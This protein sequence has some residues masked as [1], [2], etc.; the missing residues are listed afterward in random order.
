MQR[1]VEGR[2]ARR[3]RARCPGP[4]SSGA[5]SLPNSART[6]KILSVFSRLSSTYWSSL[7]GASRSAALGVDRARATVVP[8]PSRR[9]WRRASRPSPLPSSSSVMASSRSARRFSSQRVGQLV[10]RTR[11]RACRR[12]GCRRLLHRW[13]LGWRTPR[14]SRGLSPVLPPRPGSTARLTSFARFLRQ[15]RSCR[16]K[17]HP[18]RNIGQSRSPVVRLASAERGPRHETACRDDPSSTSVR[19]C[20]LQSRAVHTPVH[21]ITRAETP[22]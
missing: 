18:R 20:G 8:T 19:D 6:T 21:G 17:A 14:A 9:C 22:K 3:G 16:V 13:G 7:R 10:A 15:Q 5:R 12:I 2:R 1:A 4:G 11:R